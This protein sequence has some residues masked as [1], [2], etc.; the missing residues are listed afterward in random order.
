MANLL[1]VDGRKTRLR[2]G[3]GHDGK[4][5][6]LARPGDK[7]LSTHHAAPV[8]RGMEHQAAD[9]SIARTGT[10][11]KIQPDTPIHSGMTPMQQ[12]LRGMGH[13]VGSAPDASAANP[14]DPTVPGKRMSPT[15][16]HPG[17]T[18]QQNFNATLNGEDIFAEALDCAEPDHPAKLGR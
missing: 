10:T 12:Q 2:T 18:W 4:P 16:V 7:V 5:R 6:G 11:G 1:K 8:A 9:G 13:A 15:M 17:M 3:V 14:L